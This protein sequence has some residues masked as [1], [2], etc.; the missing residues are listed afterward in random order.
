MP[1]SKNDHN[2]CDS[3]FYTV[4]YQWS[5]RMSGI[6]IELVIPAAIGVGLDRLC[7]TVV[8]FAILGTILGMVLVFWQLVKMANFHD[9]VD[10]PPHKE[11]NDPV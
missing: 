10:T 9:G 7:G 1:S 6:A 4:L 11:D 8:L 2:D 5:A 3:H